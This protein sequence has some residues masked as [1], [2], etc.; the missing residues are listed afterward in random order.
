MKKMKK[1]K[2]PSLQ[3][4]YEGTG[5]ATLDDDL[6]NTLKKHGYEFYGSGYD[7]QEGVRDLAFDKVEKK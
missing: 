3:I 5:S 2:S 7:T 1:D 4:H 6:I